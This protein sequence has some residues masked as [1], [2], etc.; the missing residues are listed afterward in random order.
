MRSAR[1]ITLFGLAAPLMLLQISPTSCVPTTGGAGAPLTFNLPPTVVMSSDVD[2]GVVPLTVHFSSDAS[3]DDGF[4]VR[5]DWDFGDGG[6]SQEISPNHTYTTTGTFTVKLTLTDDAGLTASHS[7]IIFV[8]ER[9][10][11]IIVVDRTSS[12]TAPATFHFDGSQSFDPDAQPGET[13]L[14][15]WDFGDGSRELIAVVDHTFATSGTY[16][17]RLTVTDAVGVT[18]FTQKIIEV[19]IPRPTISFR[20]PPDYITNIVAAQT[21]PLWTH[22]VYSVTPGVPFTLRAGL[23]GDEDI[24][25]AEVAL[26]DPNTGEL[27]RTL[28]DWTNTPDIDQGPVRAAVFSA[29]P[30]GARLIAGG[31][32]GTARLYDTATG[33]LL[34]RYS[35][36]G[37]VVRALAFAPDGASIAV[38]YST[39]SL[40]LHK[41]DSGDVIR[42]LIGHTVAVEALAFSFDGS[43]LMA[44]DESGLA[45]LWNVAGGSEALMFDHGGKAVTSVAFSPVDPQRVLTGCADAT[46]RLW[47]TVNGSLIEEFAPVF[48]DGA[49]VAGH[50]DSITGVAFSPDGTLVATASADKTAKL[51]ETATASEVRTL[52]G[53]TAGLTS[54]GFSPDGKEVITGSEDHTAIIWDVTTGNKVRTLTPCASPI[55]AVGFS[56]E[57]SL[58]QTAIAAHNDIQL[59]TDPPSGNDLNLTLPTALMLKQVPT[60]ETGREYSFWIEI[61]TDRTHP[62]RTYSQARVNVIPPFTTAVEQD[63]PI[64]P[65]RGDQASVLMPATHKRQIFDLGQLE[66]GDRIFVSL[67]SLPGYGLTFTQT[68]LTAAGAVA[69]AT[70][71]EASGFSLLILD[72]EEKMFAWYDAG[73]VLFTPNSKLIIGHASTGYFIVLDATGNQLVPSVH[74]RIQRQFSDNSEPR[75]QFVHLNF[76]GGQGIA[77]SGSSKFTV[78]PFNLS[79]TVRT[80]IVARISDLLKNHNFVVSETPPENEIAPRLTI[81]FDVEDKLFTAN[82]DDRSAPQGTRPIEVSDLLMY[83]LP[84]YIDPRDETLSGRAVVAV[85]AIVDGPAS[86]LADA[87]IGF[88]IG[89]SALH[90]IGLMSG[91]RETSQPQGLV[92]DIMTSDQTQVTNA[93]LVFTTAELTELDDLG[94]IGTQDAEQLLT[95]LFGT[96]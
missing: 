3:T 57:G 5:R 18:G 58:V 47:S 9:P 42:P 27:L 40:V 65:L 29:V 7:L 15:Q 92:D 14:Y 64:I 20:S 81:Y 76:D 49:L 60:G 41:T 80:A 96:Q 86:G 68:G 91:L 45:I 71:L 46:A 89:N 74:V 62:S 32:D 95:E 54:I 83:G 2:R 4:I 28:T 59:D 19:G 21:T 52:R 85:K 79:D 34:R 51:W 8:T 90:Q 78:I 66:V 88:A 10:V 56:P 94:P 13:L 63:T 70:L 23:D 31:D 82:I 67:L 61:R 77:V 43:Q 30:N 16:R 72:A 35:G 17:V 75:Q 6:T 84:D 36:A 39:G 44:G 37:G 69:G 12:E 50:A 22:A 11:A 53:H 38:G 48:S 55:T 87:Q 26:F 24:C 33:T 1:S 25:N 93:G 73:R